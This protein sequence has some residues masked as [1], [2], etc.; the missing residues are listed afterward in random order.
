MPRAIVPG[1]I[2]DDNNMEITSAI[3]HK[4]NAR[5]LRMHL[6]DLSE[7]RALFAVSDLPRGK[8]TDSPVTG[9]VPRSRGMAQT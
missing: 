3:M 1:Q 4:H 2:D 7:A 8:W 9:R 6:V 5:A